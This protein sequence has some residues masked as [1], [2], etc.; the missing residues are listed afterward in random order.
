MSAYSVPFATDEYYSP[1]PQNPNPSQV[2]EEDDQDEEEKLPNIRGIQALVAVLGRPDAIDF[3]NG[4]IVLWSRAATR[5]AKIPYV[6][7]IDLVNEAVRVEEPVAH[8]CNVY[9]YVYMK[10][11][12]TQL[13][14]ILR[15]S[16]NFYFDRRKNLMV[17]RSCTLR[18]ALAQAALLALYI[19]GKVSYYRTVNNG[20]LKTYFRQARTRAK[21]FHKMLMAYYVEEYQQS[22]PSS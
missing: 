5:R 20:L 2:V 12:N 4:G 11:N 9:C 10:P 13:S 17:I 3:K 7:R 14:N 1:Y 21:T 6:H 16:K 18:H 19:S 22:S 15:L 8:T